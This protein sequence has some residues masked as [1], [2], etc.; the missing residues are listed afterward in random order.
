MANTSS[1]LSHVPVLLKEV[2]ETL[3][4]KAG[5]IYVDG[6]FGGG[7]YTR[8][9][10]EKAPCFVIG[11]DRDYDAIKRAE[12]LKKEYKER[13]SYAH[14][15]FSEFPVVLDAMNIGQVDGIVLDLGLSS[16]QL[17]DP[18]RGFSF[19]F[20]APLSMAMG[21][22]ELTAFDVVNNYS[23]Q[24]IADILISGEEYAGRKIARAIVKKRQEA[25]IK[26][27]RQLA[28]LVASIKFSGKDAG[29]PAT[30]TF[31]ALR[32]FVNEELIELEKTL[33]FCKNKLKS[34]GRLVV[35]TFHS[36]EDRIVK[37]FLRT[38]SGN[39]PRPSRF[40]PLMRTE[41]PPLFKLI[42]KKPITPSDREVRSNP[43]SRSAKLRWAIRLEDAHA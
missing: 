33:N 1:V 29:H 39:A 41:Y 15:R 38:E 36:L 43:R 11:L 32:I 3:A 35:V 26:T 14:A 6:T 10:L 4:P 34:G 42:Q 28:S 40:L 19:R 17:D 25:P 13:F 20:D 5:E 7:G 37:E 24:E 2:V 22:N 12:V 27:T 23:E 8:A 30:L 31:Q 21:R 16:Y 9:I 18:D